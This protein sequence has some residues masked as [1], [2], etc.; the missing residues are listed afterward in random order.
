MTLDATLRTVQ[1]LISGLWCDG[2]LSQIKSGD[3]FKMFEPDG[4]QVELPEGNRTFVADGDAFLTEDEWQVAV[5]P[6]MN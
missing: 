3:I 1:I 2:K 5:K 6:L 4:S